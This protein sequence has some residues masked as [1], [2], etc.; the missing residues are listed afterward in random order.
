[1]GQL[2]RSCRSRD[3]SRQS[4]LSEARR[5]AP[6]RW[7]C[8]FTGPDGYVVVSLLVTLAPLQLARKTC[9]SVLGT[10]ISRLMHT[11]ETTHSWDRQ[12][13]KSVGAASIG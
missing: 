3:L 6:M 1:M 5:F 7:D 9:M 4:L 8:S 2:L 12:V 10:L 11:M 13:C